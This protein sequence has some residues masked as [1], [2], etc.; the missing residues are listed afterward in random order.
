[1]WKENIKKKKKTFKKCYSFNWLQ[2]ITKINA[3][4][5]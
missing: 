5:M 3:H 1:M 2:I 4:V